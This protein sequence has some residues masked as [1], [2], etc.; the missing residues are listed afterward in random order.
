MTL[1]FFILAVLAT[2]S[3][4]A[5][6]VIAQQRTIINSSFESND[7]RGAGNPKFE[8]IPNGRVPGW[9]STSG[10]IELW[11]SGFQGVPAY[12]GSVFAEMNA[13]SSAAPLYQTICLVNGESVGW[14]FAHRART[15][16]GAATQTATLEIAS[17][18]GTFIQNLATQASTQ[19]N[20]VWNLNSG[21]TTYSGPSGLQRVQFRTTDPGSNGNFLDDIGI[22][23]NPFVELNTA[24]NAGIESDASSHIPSL[25]VS[26]TIFTP[27][28]VTVTITGGTATNGVDYTTP[29]GGTT[30]TVTIPA[31]VYTNSLMPLGISIVN[32]TLTE[33][34]ETI[35]MSIVA[36][37]SYTVTDTASC[38]GA[39]IANTTYTITDD[40]SPVVLTK[41]WITGVDGNSVNLTIAGG[42]S[43]TAGNSVVGGTTN[44]ATATAA[45]G[46][47]LTMTE[48]F[49]SGSAANYTTTLDCRRN[50]D[51]AAV[52]VSGTGLSRTIVMPADSSV[53]CTYIN[54]RKSA[55]LIIEKQWTNAKTSDAVDLSA[56]GLINPTGLS[57][58]ANSA[59]DN[60]AGMA[61]TVY[62][63]ESATLTE[64]WAVG[65]P[66]NYVATLLCTG[67]NTE[68]SGNTLTIN[69][70]DTAV[71][72][73]F[74]NARK[75]VSLQLRKTWISAVVDN[76]VTLPPTT[77]LSSNT[78][79]YNSVA[80][81]ANETDTG[82]AVTIYAG[83]TGSIMAEIFTV[84]S[85]T[86]YQSVLGCSGGTL[87]GTNAQQNNSLTINASDAGTTIICTYA[88]TFITPLTVVKTSSVISDGISLT[89]PKSIPGST[90]R[91]CILMTNP[92]SVTFST[93]AADD[94]LPANVSFVAG[95]MRS[96][97]TCANATTIEDDDALG[98]DESD[99]FG[100][101]FNSGAVTG[102]AAILAAA[103]TFAM[104]FDVTVN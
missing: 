77:G 99:P 104:V 94:I 22:N 87:S 84:G 48:A 20:P 90:V 28:A 76:A 50:S 25:I 72:C 75:S 68:L 81:T 49:T 59:N 34:S 70:A 7:P 63:A 89:N 57:S 100:M 82:N 58:I 42:S 31:G 19:A 91:Y 45:P 8:Y 96:G 66:A 56:S 60:D 46:Q 95:S 16:G 97:T 93:V 36:G 44:N 78:A 62:A 103:N 33:G 10:E 13:R 38:G 27:R 3:F 85:N 37:A 5:T 6:P 29:G 47:T 23:L 88:N 1:R 61:V 32:D 40:D 73:R 2:L 74:T 9:N 92:G 64:T 54:T 4:A 35:Q 98:S 86:A 14:S 18:L 102:I 79:Q 80:N 39:P 65:D 12:N 69:S 30:F 11:D 67:N 41:D 71:V 101:A 26:G 53:S 17:T 15:T 55:S 24:A 51:N 83:D 21:S 52:A 43:P